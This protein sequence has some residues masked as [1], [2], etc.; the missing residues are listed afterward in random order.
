MLVRRGNAQR[1]AARTRLRAVRARARRRAP[2]CQVCARRRAFC[3][4]KTSFQHSC[5]CAFR[6]CNAGER[7]LARG[8]LVL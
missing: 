1:V 7:T 4:F 3:A 2:R 8:V 5:G 6:D